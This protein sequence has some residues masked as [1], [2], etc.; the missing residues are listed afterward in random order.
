MIVAPSTI[1]DHACD[2]RWVG[3]IGGEPLRRRARRTV[4]QEKG[5]WHYS[6]VA[7]SGAVFIGVL[8]IATLA[9]ILPALVGG[10]ALTV[11]TQSMEPRYPPGT[12][13]IIRPTPID[14]ITVGDVVTFQIAAN[15]PA[16]VSHRVIARSVDTAGNT[17]LRTKGD[18]NS[19]AD[20]LPVLKVQV[21]GVVWYSIPLLG[22]LNNLIGGQLRMVLAPAVAAVLFA[23][24]GYLVVSSIRSS[25][26]RRRR[27]A[28]RAGSDIDPDAADGHRC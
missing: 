9:I 5:L 25:R 23:Y 22:W 16:V 19:L 1:T 12:L 18:N 20:P 14:E 27:A 4:K 28:T 7:L 2:A 13:I 10:T 11:L 24:A 26:A 17:T 15:K 3:A 6:A 8:A 21:K